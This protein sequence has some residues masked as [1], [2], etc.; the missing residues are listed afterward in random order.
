MSTVSFLNTQKWSD[1][2]WLWLLSPAIPAAFTAS[3]LAF[4]WS[5]QWLWLLFAP[6]LFILLFQ[7]LI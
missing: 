5:G 4:S 2:R 7:R 6:A 1:K 3:L